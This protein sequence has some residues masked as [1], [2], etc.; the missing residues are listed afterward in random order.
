MLDDKA[1]QDLIRKVRTGDDDAAAE[2]VRLYEPAIRREVRLRLRDPRLR[3]VFDSMDVCQSVLGSFFVRAASGQY[4]LDS[5]QHLLGLLVTMTR[6]KLIK[7]VHRQRASRRDHRRLA[8]N[9]VQAVDVAAPDPSPSRQVAVREL[10]HEA[11]QR[12]S[13]EERRLAELRAQGLEWADVAREL[14][15]NAASRRKQLNRALDR[16]ARELALEEE[17]SGE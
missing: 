10:L 15:G 1:F 3:R 2:L 4:E 11:H 6:N 8:A 7:Q 13:E 16:V 5:P 17:D 9:P 12:L 14:G